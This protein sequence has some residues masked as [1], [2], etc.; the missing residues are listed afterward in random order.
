MEEFKVSKTQL[1]AAL[2]TQIKDGYKLKGVK[3]NGQVFAI[4]ERE[5]E[6]SPFL[7]VEGVTISTQINQ[8]SQ[9]ALPLAIT[10]KK[11]N[12]GLGKVCLEIVKGHGGKISLDFLLRKA[13]EMYG[14]SANKVQLQSAVYA[15]DGISRVS[16]HSQLVI[17]DNYKGDL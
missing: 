3:T 16:S 8:E 12:Y 13:N 17:V 15:V 9:I 1:L 14:Y 11:N 5:E 2:S 10:P 4:V 6:V 7:E